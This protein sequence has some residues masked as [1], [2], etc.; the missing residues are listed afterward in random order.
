MKPKILLRIASIVML[1]HDVGHTFGHMGRGN[2]PLNP[3]KS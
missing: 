2:R 1:L 3:T